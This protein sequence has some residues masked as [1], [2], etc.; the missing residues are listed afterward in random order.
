MT[1]PTV[2]MSD[3]LDHLPDQ[4]ARAD[5]QD[6]AKFT[7]KWL[8]TADLG[9]ASSQ[10]RRDLNQAVKL[11]PGYFGLAGR[12]QAAEVD[13]C[14][15][16][17]QFTHVCGYHSPY[18]CGSAMLVADDV[19]LTCSHVVTADSW[20]ESVY[21]GMCNAAT[22][23]KDLWIK[24]AGELQP[25]APQ[26]GAY[27]AFQLWLEK[28]NPALGGYPD[29]PVGPCAITAKIWGNDLSP[30]EIAWP[31]LAA[32]DWAV[33]R[34]Y[35]AV[36][37]Y[38]GHAGWKSW[39]LVPNGVKLTIAGID[40]SNCPEIKEGIPVSKSI[41]GYYSKGGTVSYEKGSTY[42]SWVEHA[43]GD[44]HMNHAM[45]VPPGFSGAPLFHGSKSSPF[46]IHNADHGVL[47]AAAGIGNRVI[48]ALYDIYDI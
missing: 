25:K 9:C 14:P 21:P 40:W 44:V 34:I 28:N 24:V 19:V 5:F 10:D 11:F 36:G 42:Q 35:P 32:S 37:K 47:M 31:H 16:D 33:V 30:G 18:G 41:F 48:D 45:D 20:A 8:H 29:P 6:Q 12:A 17:P 22:Y 13:I 27:N 7:R 39:T 26:I 1:V 38:T 46:A 15:V 4:A 23:L 3:L 43:N 2:Q